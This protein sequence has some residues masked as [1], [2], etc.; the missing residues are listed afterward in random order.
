MSTLKIGVA[1]IVLAAALSIPAYA[2]ENRG[3]GGGH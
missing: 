1:M 2:A 3:G